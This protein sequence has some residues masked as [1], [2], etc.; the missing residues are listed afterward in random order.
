MLGTLLY[1][2]PLVLNRLFAEFALFDTSE[3][4][5]TGGLFLD[6]KL[7][8]R[9]RVVSKFLFSGFSSEVGSIGELLKK[10]KE[11]HR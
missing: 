8:S 11:G 6:G 9:K 1:I 7:E 3:C 10:E 5:R 2:G 4:A